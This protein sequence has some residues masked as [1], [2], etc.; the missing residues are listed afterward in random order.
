MRLLWIPRSLTEGESYSLD[1]Q[2]SKRLRDVLRLERGDLLLGRDATMHLYDLMVESCTKNE[3]IL[4]VKTVKPLPKSVCSV[5]LWQALPKG[6]KLDSIVRMAVEA[7]VSRIVLVPTEFS[8]RADYNGDH[9]RERLER[10]AYEAVM[11]SGSLYFR[12][13]NYASS[14]NQLIE[15]NPEGVT[16]LV[17]HQEPQGALSVHEAITKATTTSY[18]IFIGT[19]G[20]F[21]PAEVIRLHEKNWIFVQ[22]GNTIL[23]TET[24]GI[25][26]LGALNIIHKERYAWFIPA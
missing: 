4:R 9:K 18:R 25:F 8:Q 12:E 14:F 11:Q 3:V 7:G 16:S 17:C 26:M 13:L 20:G 15:E 24:A 1:R 22:L 2:E 10:I 5:E 23:R 21:S 6:K 19:E